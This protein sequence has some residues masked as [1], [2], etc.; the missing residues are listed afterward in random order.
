MPSTGFF[1][2]F[3][4]WAWC[5]GTTTTAIVPPACPHMSILNN[6]HPQSN[7]VRLA[8]KETGQDASRVLETENVL[9]LGQILRLASWVLLSWV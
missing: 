8:K 9:S 5:A 3:Q 6:P 7:Q 4:G 1:E 2:I